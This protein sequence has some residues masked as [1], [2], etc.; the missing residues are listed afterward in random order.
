MKER[1]ENRLYAIREKNTPYYEAD[2][3]LY[4]E[5]SG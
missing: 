4:F 1:G 3:Q 2:I 5:K